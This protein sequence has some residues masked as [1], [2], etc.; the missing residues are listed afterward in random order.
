MSYRLT[1]ANVTNFK[2]RACTGQMFD[3][4][5]VALLVASHETVEAELATLRDQYDRHI[6]R[7]IE[8]K[9]AI[10]GQIAAWLRRYADEHSGSHPANSGHIACNAAANAIERGEWRD[11]PPVVLRGGTRVWTESMP[12]RDPTLEGAAGACA[13]KSATGPLCDFCQA[14]AAFF[15]CACDRCGARDTSLRNERTFLFCRDRAVCDAHRQRRIAEAP[16]RNDP[17]SPDRCNC[18]LARFEDPPCPV[19][20]PEAKP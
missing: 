2:L 4:G 14:S 10:P 11:P 8:E 5:D 19:H 12:E 7:H 9:R 3:S 1:P 15:G 20:G 17:E 16:C 13:C 18:A 6:A